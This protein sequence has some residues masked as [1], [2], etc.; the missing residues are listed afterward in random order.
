MPFPIQQPYKTEREQSSLWYAWFFWMI[1]NVWTVLEGSYSTSDEK[2]VTQR[3]HDFFFWFRGK[4]WRKL[5]EA[6]IN[7]FKLWKNCDG[8]FSQLFLCFRWKILRK[9]AEAEINRYKQIL[10]SRWAYLF[11]EWMV[12]I[13]IYY[14]LIPLL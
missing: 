10:I 12:Q 5:A 9:S 11:D 3:F 8:T 6:E 14:F 13:P 4:I 1:V 2:I 7:R